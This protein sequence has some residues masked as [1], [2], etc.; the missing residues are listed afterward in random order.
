MNDAFRF[1]PDK[2]QYFF[3][4]RRVTGITEALSR[5]GLAP[6]KPTNPA[7]LANFKAAGQRGTEV[8]RMC[9][10]YD[11][12]EVADYEFDPAIVGYLVAWRGFCREY[13]F[14]ADFTERPLGHPVY[15][16]GG[17]PDAGGYSLKLDAYCTVERKTRDLQDHDAFQV[18][19]Q[20]LLLEQEQGAKPGSRL[21]LVSLKA[22]GRYF[23]KDVTAERRQ[24]RGLFL[25]AV[26]IANYQIGRGGE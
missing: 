22:D 17:I 3:G 13:G 12:G 18:A 10:L 5:T 1:D 20:E 24:R 19:A 8:H 26:G 4:D 25:A 2:H 15:N 9:E 11:T 23:P 21:L 14:E 6:A 16:Y 7:I